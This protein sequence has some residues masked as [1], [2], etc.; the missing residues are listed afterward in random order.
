M[1]IWIG[2]WYLTPT[3]LW[4]RSTAQPAESCRVLSPGASLPFELDRETTIGQN[5]ATKTKSTDLMCLERSSE[6]TRWRLQ[7]NRSREDP[8]PPRLSLGTKCVDS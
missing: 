7:A 1:R 5:K 3:G 4:L 8:L 2:M 6:S